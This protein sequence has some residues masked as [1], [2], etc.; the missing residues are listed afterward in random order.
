MGTESRGQA[1]VTLGD[2]FSERRTG[3]AS[4]GRDHLREGVRDDSQVSAWLHLWGGSK[5][6]GL[7]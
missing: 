1:R 7:K 2:L 3:L 6:S 5:E 4:C